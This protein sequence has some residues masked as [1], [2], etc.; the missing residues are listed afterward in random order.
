MSVKL[1]IAAAALAL[2]AAAPATKPDPDTAAWWRITAQLSNDSMEGRDTGSAAYE[3]AA[4]L[5]AAKFAAAGLKPAGENDSWF[6]PVPMHEIRVPS[7]SITIGRRKLVFLH[8]LTIAPTEGMLRKV[9]APLIYAGYCSENALGDV[10]G[11]IVICHGTHRSAL[12]A[13][14]DREA[15]VR[16]AGATGMLTIADPGFTV[17]PPRWPYAY[18]R[19]VTLSSRAAK[20]RS[21]S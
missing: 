12:P 7:A 4:R 10:R 14:A 19:T 13:A 8:D 21:V 1:S 6:Q 2:I 5:V 3:R 20:S 11:K 17:E 18:A 9:D 16:A 15:A